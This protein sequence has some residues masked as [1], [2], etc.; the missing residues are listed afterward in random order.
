[1]SATSALLRLFIA[2]TLPEA[3][4]AAI[5]PIQQRLERLDTSH[6]IRWA[7]DDSL[8]LTLKFLGETPADRVEAISAAMQAACKQAP[9]RLNIE[10]LGWFPTLRSP[11][12]IWLGVTGDVPALHHL[13][14]AVERT[15]A[16]LGF[17]TEAR[18]FSPHL[19]LGRTRQQASKAAL[20]SFAEEAGQL[21]VAQLGSWQVPELVLMRSDLRPSGAVYTVLARTALS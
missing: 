15:V 16:P 14:D 4:H 7:S 12:V 2:I 10:G 8:H 3:I 9:F 19:T 6:A 20:A 13:R 5:V 18:P 1:M 17:P 21:P 11:R